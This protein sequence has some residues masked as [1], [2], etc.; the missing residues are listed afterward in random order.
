MNDHTVESAKHLVRFNN[1]ISNKYT[2]QIVRHGLQYT[3]LK[4]EL[5]WDSCECIPIIISH[6]MT[7]YKQCVKIFISMI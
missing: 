2:S 1:K 5:Y 3:R 4:K 7:I 6:V